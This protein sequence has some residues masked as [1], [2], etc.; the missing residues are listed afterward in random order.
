MPPYL[1]I[2]LHLAN[3]YGSATCPFFHVTS[4]IYSSKLQYFNNP[5]DLNWFFPVEG[6]STNRLFHLIPPFQSTI[7]GHPCC[8]KTDGPRSQIPDR[9]V[10]PGPMKINVFPPFSRQHHA[11]P[12]IWKGLRLK[13]LRTLQPAQCH[14]Q[15]CVRQKCPTGEPTCPHLHYEKLIISH[16]ATNIT[17]IAGTADLLLKLE[18]RVKNKEYFT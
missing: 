10:C 13:G 8:W 16:D 6:R 7:W 9:S 12:D 1:E 14:C 11:P 2:V 5:E 17:V 3:A 4:C 15:R 18:F